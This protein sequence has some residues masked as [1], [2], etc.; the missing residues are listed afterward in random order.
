MCVCGCLL[1]VESVGGVGWASHHLGWCWAGDHSSSGV[2]AEEAATTNIS[3]PGILCSPVH[4]D[5][6]HGGGLYGSKEQHLDTRNIVGDTVDSNTTD[7]QT[8]NIS[9]QIFF[10]TSKYFFRPGSSLTWRPDDLAAQLG[11]AA[12]AGHGGNPGAGGGHLN[13]NMTAS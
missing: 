2:T 13:L 10:K 7:K 1:A 4:N 8:H 12:G 5:R 11:Q 3:S 9:L 6:L